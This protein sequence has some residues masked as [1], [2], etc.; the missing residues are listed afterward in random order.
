V[1]DGFFEV[2]TAEAMADIYTWLRYSASRQLT[3]QRNYNTQPRILSAAQVRWRCVICVLFLGCGGCVAA[4][5][6]GCGLL[7]FSAQAGNPC[8]YVCITVGHRQQGSSNG[9]FIGRVLRAVVH[10]TPRLPSPADLA[11]QPTSC[12]ASYQ[13][14]R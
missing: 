13:Q 9:S 1:L 3:W 8:V 6:I 5:S 4:E 12:R 2:D 14:R 10:G 11:A 7:Q